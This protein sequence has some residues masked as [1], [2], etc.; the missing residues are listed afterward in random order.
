MLDLLACSEV[1]EFGQLGT[2]L[3]WFR[4]YSVPK[5]DEFFFKRSTASLR[6]D[7]EFLRKTDLPITHSSSLSSWL[8]VLFFFFLPRLNHAV[9]TG[10]LVLL[11][12]AV[13]LP[14]QLPYPHHHLCIIL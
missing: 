9:R 2:G 6:G 14:S 11:V 4:E 13:T 3:S 5:V 12:A 1:Y 8:S 7:H 10:L